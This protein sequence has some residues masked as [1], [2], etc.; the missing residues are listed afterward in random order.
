MDVNEILEYCQLKKGVEET[1]PFNPETLV[2]KVGGKM[3][4][5]IPL[6]KQPITISV[7]TDPEWSAEL[8]EQYHQIEGAYHMNKTHWNSV[9][10]EGLKPELIFKLIDHSYDLIVRSLT[11]KKREELLNS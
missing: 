8:R 6:E 1:F 9:T 11:K 3:F 10:C 5:L 2:L 4:A 7:K